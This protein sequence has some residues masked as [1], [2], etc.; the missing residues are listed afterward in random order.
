MLKEM[1]IDVEMRISGETMAVIKS[2][3]L[4]I[5]HQEISFK[6]DDI[7][8]T[9]GKKTTPIGQIKFRVSVAEDI[10]AAAE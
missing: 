2:N 7:A 1:S 8:G 5:F 9:V 10:P 4:R 3:A 6:L